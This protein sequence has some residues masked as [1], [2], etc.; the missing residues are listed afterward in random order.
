MQVKR[1]AEEAGFE[2][3]DEYVEDVLTH[4]DNENLDHLFTP[5]RLEHL[6]RVSV[7]VKAGGK[8]YTSA[9]VDDHFRKKWDA[10]PES[11]TS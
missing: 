10:W 7:E 9:E 3:V 1:K 4:E 5:D 8:S 6:H 11:P 2:T